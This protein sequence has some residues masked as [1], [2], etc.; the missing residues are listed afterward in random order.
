MPY[1][2]N[3]PEDQRA[4]LDAIGVQSLDELFS[5]Y[6]QRMRNCQTELFKLLIDIL[7]SFS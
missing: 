6:T 4:M 3:T 5:S 1:I 7:K 2:S